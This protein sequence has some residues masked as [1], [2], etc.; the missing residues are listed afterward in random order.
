MFVD[1][2]HAQRHL[3]AYLARRRN[4]TTVLLADSP[5]SELHAHHCAVTGL[6]AHSGADST[7]RASTR[8]HDV[9]CDVVSL[10]LDGQG[11][12]RTNSYLCV[13]G[14]DD[15]SVR[16][17]QIGATRVHME[18]YDPAQTRSGTSM[19]VLSSWDGPKQYRAVAVR[20]GA[21]RPNSSLWEEDRGGGD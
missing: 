18:R 17:R 6:G 13:C 3:P 5:R 8:R 14:A 16:C 1:A 2:G 20:C 9:R 12:R 10:R 21:V 7:R 4:A 15:L 11:H 19:L